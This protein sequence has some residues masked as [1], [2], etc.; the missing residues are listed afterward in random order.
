MLLSILSLLLQAAT[1]TPVASATP[2]QES[3]RTTG[4]RVPLGYATYEGTSLANGVSQFL[5]M[6]YAAPPLGNNRLRLPVD[7]PKE[8]GVVSAKK[9]ETLASCHTLQLSRPRSS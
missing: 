8:T 2:L 1:L 5:G 7:P 6:R 4:P 9:V 3:S